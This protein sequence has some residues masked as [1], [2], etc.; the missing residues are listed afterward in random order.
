M[1]TDHPEYSDALRHLAVIKVGNGQ[2]DE[3]EPLQRRSIAVSERTRGATHRATLF[4]QRNLGDI[5]ARQNRTAEA[6]QLFR[7]VLSRLQGAES[8][9]E[10]LR[11]RTY[12]SIGGLDDC[13]GTSDR[14]RCRTRCG[15]PD[16]WRPSCQLGLCGRRLTDLLGAAQVA[17]GRHQAAEAAFD[18]SIA[19]FARTLGPGHQG[20]AAGHAAR[21]ASRLAVGRIAEALDDYRKATATLAFAWS[22]TTTEQGRS[23]PARSIEVPCM[24]VHGGHIQAAWPGDTVEP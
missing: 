3:A 17:A 19:A 18:Q 11:A 6:E 10:T 12:Q 20:V 23:D 4:G 1:G 16:F 22:S 13:D 9:A 24:R 8:R 7:H 14:G 2:L 21:G 15:P 5:L